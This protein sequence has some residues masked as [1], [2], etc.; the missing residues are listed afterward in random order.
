MLPIC[1]DFSQRRDCQ[2]RHARFA[3]QPLSDFGGRRAVLIV[4]MF[5]GLVYNVRWVTVSTVGR[6]S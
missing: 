1:E 5:G 6:P 3:G 2:P 4:P